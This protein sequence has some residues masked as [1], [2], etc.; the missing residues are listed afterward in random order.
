MSLDFHLSFDENHT[1][2]KHYKLC[3]NILII[4][5]NLYDIN[6]AV[7]YLT[8]PFKA[9]TVMTIETQVSMWRRNDLAMSR[10]LASACSY[11]S[12]M[13]ISIVKIAGLNVVS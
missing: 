9:S 5:K 1:L 13:W 12:L 10:S 11:N 8:L 6:C 2:K 3:E 7:F 4:T